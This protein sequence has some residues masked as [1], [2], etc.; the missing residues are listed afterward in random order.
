MRRCQEGIKRHLCDNASAAASVL[1]NSADGTGCAGGDC[2]MMSSAAAMQASLS[3]D[4]VTPPLGKSL[5]LTSGWSPPYLLMSS[6]WR[7]E[8]DH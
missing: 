7:E 1:A 3:G 4:T 2:W 8:F 5:Q 6:A